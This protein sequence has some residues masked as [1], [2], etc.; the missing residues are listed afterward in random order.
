M[1]LITFTDTT[2]CNLQ[3]LLQCFRLLTQTLHFVFQLDY[4]YAPG[5]LAVNREQIKHEAEKRQQLRHKAIDKDHDNDIDSN[6]DRG[7]SQSD[8]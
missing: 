5:L 1:Y 7:T 8:V 2:S 3:S 6:S 4:E